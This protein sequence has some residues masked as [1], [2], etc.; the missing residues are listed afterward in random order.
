LNVFGYVLLALSLVLLA[1]SLP[2]IIRSIRQ[3]RV[4]T[5]RQWALVVGVLLL[6][7]AALPNPYFDFALRTNSTDTMC[8]L[9][10]SLIQAEY[11]HEPR[12]NTEGTSR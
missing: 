5:L 7:V 10:L 6:M 12:L 4:L 9:S 1:V 11:L 2:G 3:L 8:F